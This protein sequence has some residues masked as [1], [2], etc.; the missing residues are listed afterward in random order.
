MKNESCH[1]PMGV[2]AV[3]FLSEGTYKIKIY[4]NKYTKYL[5]ASKNIAPMFP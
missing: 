1:E 3:V 5:P 2:I 4:Q